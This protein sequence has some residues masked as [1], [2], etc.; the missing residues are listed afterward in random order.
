PSAVW[1]IRD[2]GDASGWKMIEIAAEVLRNSF[3]SGERGA[4][5]VWRL[6]AGLGN[7]GAGLPGPGRAPVSEGVRATGAAPRAPARGGGQGG[8]PRP[9]LA[10]VFRLRLQPRSPCRRGPGRA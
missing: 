5:P 8:H 6:R 2:G 4:R 7:S 9:P 3:E 10:E 1:T